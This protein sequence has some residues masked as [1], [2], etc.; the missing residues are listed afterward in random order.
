MQPT[1]IS[2][3]GIVMNET[4]FGGTTGAIDITVLGGTPTYT[5]AWTGGSTNEDL[6]NATAGND[7]VMVTDSKGCVKTAIYAITQPTEIYLSLLSNEPSCNGS[8]NGSLSV[9]ASQGVPGYTY[10]WSTVPAQTS[11][12]ASNLTAGNYTVTVTDSKGCGHCYSNA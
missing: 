3:T 5:F 9:V 8:T 10:S 7:T 11:A 2:I 6:T 1:D 4:C 12:S